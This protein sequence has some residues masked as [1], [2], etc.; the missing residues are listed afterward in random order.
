MEICIVSS[1]LKTNG[2]WVGSI[3]DKHGHTT[4]IGDCYPNSSQHKAI[5]LGCTRLIYRCS[6]VT[7]ITVRSNYN[8]LI[9]AMNSW[10][11]NWR[12]NNWRNAKRKPIEYREEWEALYHYSSAA[13]TKWVFCR[14]GTNAA[15]DHIR[16]TCDQ[17]V[18][19]FFPHDC[20]QDRTFEDLQAQA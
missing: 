18:T 17:V 13:Q 11:H 15:I 14:D 2:A 9:Q 12:S 10:I 1:H 8:N 20:M 19:G 3:T 5:I 6:D 16:Q 7:Q 4:T